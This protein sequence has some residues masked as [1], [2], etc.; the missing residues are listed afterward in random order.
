MSCKRRWFLSCFRVMYFFDNGRFYICCH[1]FPARVSSPMW[2]NEMISVN[3]KIYIYEF[4]QD[5]LVY[6][7]VS[8]W[9]KTSIIYAYMYKIPCFRLHP[10]SKWRM[11]GHCMWERRHVPRASVAAILR[12]SPAVVRHA[13]PDTLVLLSMSKQCRLNLNGLRIYQLLSNLIIF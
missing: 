3:N 5:Y 9:V 2:L 13:L 6:T 1:S 10:S 11:R 8:M 4:I 12:L 7:T